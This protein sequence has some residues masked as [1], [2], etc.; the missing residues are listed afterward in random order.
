MKVVV[1]TADGSSQLVD[2]DSSVPQV[3]E[4]QMRDADGELLMSAGRPRTRK[5]KLGQ[6]DLVP[7]LG[8]VRVYHELPL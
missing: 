3:I 8:T 6:F 4:L 5:F 1:I 7:G 2:A